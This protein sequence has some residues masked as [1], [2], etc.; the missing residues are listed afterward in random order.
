MPKQRPPLWEQQQARLTT[1]SQAKYNFDLERVDEYTAESGWRLDDYETELPTEPPGAPMPDGA[2]H[3]AQQVL[4][5]YTFPPPSLIT[6]IFTPDTPLE[7]RT[8]VLRGRF[9][10]FTFWFGVRIGAVIDKEHTTPDGPEQVWGYSYSTL[11]GHFEKGRI[12]FT[13]HKQL[14]TGRVMFRI[15][16]VSQLGLIRNPFYWL[17]FRLF[18]RMLQRKFARESLKRMRVQVE[19]ALMMQKTS[20]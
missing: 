7:D 17:G 3:A 13:I 9:L 19:Q 6:G 14:E 20:P 12:E 18:G 4:R 11:E 1:Y 10:G 2:W 5:N 15:H 16:A 8:M